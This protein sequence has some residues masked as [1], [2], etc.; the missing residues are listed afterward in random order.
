M[1]N[2][3]EYYENYDE[4]VR[5]IKDNAHKIEFITTMYCLDKVVKPGSKI[6]EVGQEQ[7][8]IHLV[9]PIW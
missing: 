9:L 2:I 7:E 4:E 6:L 5:L 8:D 3:L 1:K